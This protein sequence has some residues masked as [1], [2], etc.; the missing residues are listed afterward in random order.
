MFSNNIDLRVYLFQN[1]FKSFYAN[2]MN[3]IFKF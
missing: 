3:K 1:K 2:L